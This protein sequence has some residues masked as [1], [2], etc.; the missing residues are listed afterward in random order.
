MLARLV[1]PCLVVAGIGLVVA[2]AY[3]LGVVDHVRDERRLAETVDGAGPFGPLLFVGLMVL[4]VP[5]NVPG[6]LFVLPATLLF[7]TVGGIALSLVGGFLASA[8]GVY[9]ARRLGR[10]VFEARMPPRIRRLEARLSERGFWTVVVLRMFTYLMQPIDWL[11]GV[12]SIPMRTVLAGTFVGLIPPTLVVALGG[13][14]L[15]GRVL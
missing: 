7:G 6:V 4:L 13:G 12:S 10:A 2:A 5:L 9:A 11:C 1:R 15:L 3:G 14:G 8:V